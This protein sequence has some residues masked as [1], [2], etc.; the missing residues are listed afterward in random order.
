MQRETMSNPYIAPHL[1]ELP[2]HLVLIRSTECLLLSKIPFQR[3][4][5]D[6]GSGDGHFAAAL[7][8][9]PADAGVDVSIGAIREAQKRKAHRNLIGASATHLPFRDGS[10]QTVICNSTFEHIRDTDH[11]VSEA[12]RVLDTGGLLLATMPSEYF[13]SYMLP[14]RLARLL[15]LRALGERYVR[16]FNRRAQHF[17]LDAPEVWRHRF[18]A[19]GLQVTQFRY[20]FPRASHVIFELA[21]YTSAP[22][23]LVKR[24]LGRW[25]I[26]RGKARFRPLL[27]LVSQAVRLGPPDRGSGLFFVCQKGH[28]GQ[29]EEP[30]Q[31]SEPVGDRR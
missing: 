6:I 13:N 22:S 11:A 17:H 24:L 20:Y 16:W 5:L 28:A 10:F 3:P 27:W 9:E 14:F 7:F 21:H 19:A 4:L 26:W 2:L 15:G 8:A 12:G 25:V 29:G 23:L 30:Q 18:E 31:A 1:A